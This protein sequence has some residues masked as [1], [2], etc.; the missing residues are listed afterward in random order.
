MQ[1]SNA[2]SP[3]ARRRFSVSLVCTSVALVL[4]CSPT[5]QAPETAHRVISFSPLGTQLVIDLERSDALVAV[6]AGAPPP[7]QTTELPEIDP[8][9]VLDH[10][11]TLVLIPVPFDPS[12]VEQWRARGIEILDIAPHGFADVYGALR[13]L[14]NH[15][16]AVDRATERIR[17]LADPLAFLSTA[18]HD[19]TARR[20]LVAPLVS[21]DPPE[22]AGGHSPTVDLVQ[23]AGAESTT[24][25]SDRQ[26][27]PI[28][29]AELRALRVDLLLVA[30][31]RSPTEPQRRASR[32]LAPPGA[33]VEFVEID[34]HRLWLDRP[35]EAACAVRLRILGSDAPGALDQ[36]IEDAERAA[37]RARRQTGD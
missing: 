32:K 31:P 29:R 21:L 15:L 20:P 28:G 30:L 19:D 34:E 14:G 10:D 11:P 17:A 26:R 13:Q 37:S 1:V 23:I 12:Y 18:A 35:I 9:Q 2:R 27:I 7:A 3:Q 16:G 8:A 4:A 36:C 24:H 5:G 25:G 6:G 22:L 33:R